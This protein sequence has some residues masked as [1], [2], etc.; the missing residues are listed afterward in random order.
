MAYLP[1]LLKDPAWFPAA[2]DTKVGTISFARISRDALSKEAFLDQRMDGSVTARETVSLNDVM[3]AVAGQAHK[4]PAFV[5]HSAF[6]CS[7]LLASA[8]D[9]SGAVLSLKEPNILMDLANAFRVDGQARQSRQYGET[10]AQTIFTL[11]A[12]SSDSNENILIKPT[13]T[14]NNL[15]PFAIKSGAPVLLLYGS[16]RSFLVSVL[17][18]GEACKSFV[19]GQ[20]NI[21][22]LDGEGLAAIPQ[23]QAVAFTDLQAAAIVWRHQLELFQR[24]I[25]ATPR[26]QVACLDFKHLTATPVPILQA[27]T[28]HLNLPHTNA[29]LESIANGPVFRRNA[30]FIGQVFSPEQVDQD[31]RMIEERYGQT[32]DLIESWANRTNLGTELA[33][34]LSGAIVA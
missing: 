16:L 24:A 8:L 30:K 19:R 17:K 18:K 15:L 9:A 6:C 22:A 5:F 27:V 7:T 3:A 4:P 23:R 32:L 20:Y 31:V 28:R 33:K 2:L 12:T 11:L 10:L 26:E 1:E 29:E 13:N 14:A 34:P 21:F 25:A